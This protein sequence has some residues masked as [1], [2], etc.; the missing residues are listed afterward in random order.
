M[1]LSC[2]LELN[3]GA[4]TTHIASAPRFLP[5][6]L[7]PTLTQQGDSSPSPQA[8]S[9]SVQAGCSLRQCRAST[10]PGALCPPAP[11]SLR[12]C[13]T[14]Q[15]KDLPSHPFSCFGPRVLCGKARKVPSLILTKYSQGSGAACIDHVSASQGLKGDKEIN[16]YDFRTHF[17]NAY[18]E[19]TTKPLTLC[20]DIAE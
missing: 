19:K 15:G 1:V 11:I 6:A 14:V 8:D 7:G 3:Q 2:L 9:W 12:N 20:L 13:K 18:Y 17:K 4:H 10:L 5:T 16:K